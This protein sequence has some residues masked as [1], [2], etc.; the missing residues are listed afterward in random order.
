MTENL[1]AGQVA[2]IARKTEQ[3]TVFLAAVKSGAAALA[4]DP[5]VTA[6][7]W[8]DFSLKVA[9]AEGASAAWNLLQRMV[10]H[11]NGEICQGGV[12]GVAMDLLVNGADDS[13]SGRSND[14]KRARFDGVRAACSDMKWL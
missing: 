2:R 5:N 6:A 14:L 9:E 4:A 12:N 7:N 13:W 11:K 3:A 8:G 10:D 1:G